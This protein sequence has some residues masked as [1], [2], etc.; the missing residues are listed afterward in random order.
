MNTKEGVQL[1]INRKASGS[2]NVKCHIFIPSDA[3]VNKINR[4]LESVTY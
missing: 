2:G 3:Q 1:A 4:V